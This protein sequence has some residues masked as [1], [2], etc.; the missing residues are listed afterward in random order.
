ML[1][2]IDELHII[3]Y[4]YLLEQGYEHSA[5]AF[6]SEAQVKTDLFDPTQL[7]MGLL[8][9]IMQKALQMTDIE[10]HMDSKGCLH[11]CS[12]PLAFLKPHSCAAI[13]IVNQMMP[14]K[15]LEIKKHSLQDRTIH[16][17]TEL[18]KPTLVNP[19]QSLNQIYN[20]D[21]AD[22]LKKQ[23]THEDHQKLTMLEQK[24]QE[25]T[26]LSS[27]AQVH[28][29]DA[30][31]YVIDK[32]FEVN[33]NI[34]KYQKQVQI[35]QPQI[36]ISEELLLKEKPKA[37]KV[38]LYKELSLSPINC[39]RKLLIPIAKCDCS[40][41][42]CTCKGQIEKQEVFCWGSNQLN[43]SFVVDQ[44]LKTTSNLL[45]KL[46]IKA[47][48]VEICFSQN[49]LVVV[50]ENAQISVFKMQSNQIKMLY[51]GFPLGSF[52]VTKALY[53]DQY[54]MLGG[55]CS[56]PR[57]FCLTTQQI[58]EQSR[59]DPFRAVKAEDGSAFAKIFFQQDC[60]MENSCL[61]VLDMIY[62]Q[63]EVIFIRSDG[64]FQVNVIEKDEQFV[65]KRDFFNVKLKQI[66]MHEKSIFIIT[67][68]QII[69]E[70]DLQYIGPNEKQ[71][72]FV[73]NQ[74]F[75]LK[76]HGIVCHT[77]QKHIVL[78]NLVADQ[79]L[80]KNDWPVEADNVLMGG[81]GN[82]IVAT[83]GNKI[84]RIDVL[85]EQIREEE[86]NSTIT[87]IDQTGQLFGLGGTSLIKVETEV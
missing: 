3:I 47:K 30:V 31:N 82:E 70:F 34:A 63:N 25:Q 74:A 67:E 45:K 11:R 19:Q 71:V 50:Q 7:P 86:V 18:P 28:S 42:Q 6:H 23:I 4:R 32:V 14:Q 53:Q 17:L 21:T 24:K 8:I 83:M 1:I 48:I 51:A 46:K 80:M 81:C 72:E 64:L 10:L 57:I 85:D 87:A 29:L 43:L 13:N 20:T 41:L 55:F 9:N 52:R 40:L 15:P 59:W 76:N 36:Q 66:I 84:L 44:Q 38:N 68:G 77:T 37:Q 26:I 58:I 78:F 73:V 54:L 62:Q 27:A 79:I 12:Q 2:D 61:E 69:Y 33:I 22:Y 56:R 75:L 60:D 39:A 49:R 65:Q 16:T 35:L 5:F